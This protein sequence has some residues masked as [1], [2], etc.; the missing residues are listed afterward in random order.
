[1]IIL[2]YYAG[3]PLLVGWKERLE[4]LALPYKLVEQPSDS[5]PSLIDGDKLMTGATNINEYIDS[6]ESFV[7]GWYEDRCDRYDFD[8]DAPSGLKF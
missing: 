8:P 1:M 6:L 3:T 7:E 4:R 2:N 5:E